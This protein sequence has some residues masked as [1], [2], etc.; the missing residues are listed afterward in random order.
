ML[1]AT[2]EVGF[3]RP[4]EQL[5]I[6]DHHSY[7]THGWVF[8]QMVAALDVTNVNDVEAGFN[9]F[10]DSAFTAFSVDPATN[11][12]TVAA[13]THFAEKDKVLVQVQGT[14]LP[15]P[16]ID[17]AF[18]ILDGDNLATSA[19]V[20]TPID[21]TDA[22]SGTIEMR[23]LG[24]R[25]NQGFKTDDNGGVYN[26][27]TGTGLWNGVHSFRNVRMTGSS[28]HMKSFVHEQF[29]TGD[30]RV[31]R[32]T[33]ENC[34]FDRPGQAG[35]VSNGSYPTEYSNVRYVFRDCHW[36]SKGGNLLGGS[37]WSSGAA[38]GLPQGLLD[39]C[40][41]EGS[42]RAGFNPRGTLHVSRQVFDSNLTIAAN[43]AD[44]PEGTVFSLND[45]QMTP[46]AFIDITRPPAGTPL[47][48][49]LNRVR[50]LDPTGAPIQIRL[51]GAGSDAD[52]RIS[53][54]DSDVSWT[55]ADVAA[56]AEFDV[57]PSAGSPKLTYG[58]TSGAAAT[59]VAGDKA[60]FT[61]LRADNN[62]AGD[63]SLDGSTSGI[64]LAAD[65]GEYEVS[66]WADTE[67]PA[68]GDATT[69]EV[70]INGAAFSYMTVN[71]PGSQTASWMDLVDT[72]GAAQTIEVNRSSVT[73]TGRLDVKV[74]VEQLG[75]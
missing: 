44:S 72:T 55:A 26:L 4:I 51:L 53:V 15:E 42:V 58:H 47:R 74:K 48:V 19:T 38:V 28:P 63:I 3:G 10:W 25:I 6:R 18:Y 43:S 1:S 69:L 33:H 31:A 40:H 39:G 54:R 75:S 21:F 22:G 37:N 56:I 45:C 70:L 35:G 24:S 46:G 11:V 73:G 59:F 36:T 17:Q 62:G 8:A 16:L 66:I 67:A 60:T 12:V 27:T 9:P 7:R 61:E 30:R 14:D 68:A 65:T 50:L 64:V 71:E 41:F 20:P 29:S 57:T 52:L 49:E 2:A 23:F 32:V 5:T 34:E 13:P